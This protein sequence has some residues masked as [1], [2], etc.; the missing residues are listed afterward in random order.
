MTAKYARRDF[1]KQS[2]ALAALGAGAL[3]ASA[4]GLFAEEGRKVENKSTDKRPN[5]VFVFSD[6]QRWDTLG[7]YGQKLPISPNLDKMAKEG[8]LFENAFTCQPVCGPARAVIQTGKYA[9]ETGCFRNGI[10]L[11]IDEVTMADRLSMAGY[12][13]GYI[14]KWHLASDAEHKF[15]TRPIPPE[16]RG[17]YKDYWL[18][19]D[20]LEFTSHG[21]DGH[22]FN[23]AMEQVDFK[24]YR[25]DALTD[26]ALDYLR[27]RDGKRPFFLFISYIEPHFQNDHKHFEGPEGS[28]EKYKDFIPPEDL[29][30]REGD[31]QEEYPDYLGCCESLDYNMGRIREELEAL[32]LTDNTVVI[33]TSDH[34]CHFRTRNSEY[35]RSCHESSIRIPMIA[36]GPGFKGGKVVHEMTS[37]IDAAP[38]VLAAAGVKRPKSMRGRPIQ[39]AVK[40]AKD[41]RKD[42]FVQISES[43]TG[44]AI[45]TKKWKY[46]VW[47]TKEEA[48]GKPGADVY[49]ESHLYDLEADP[50]EANNLVADPKLA[51][52]R[53]DLRSLLIRRMTEIGE[54][55]PKVLPASEVSIG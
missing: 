53:K 1:L 22:M 55:K 27:T 43:G 2:A 28:K 8:V 10:A 25:A 49:H 7:C 14:G 46:C 23:A 24:G 29:V 18:A 52:V 12:E 37:L 36:Y 48:D 4:E 26:Y 30:G 51:E 34:G 19:S 35:K 38:T 41:W 40:G 31:W 42:V 16:R 21:Y 3:G 54:K 20:V 9:T 13:V 17:G 15:A 50:Y 11:P 32:G 33:Y 5:I 44:R 6:Q 47:V 39:D 45:R